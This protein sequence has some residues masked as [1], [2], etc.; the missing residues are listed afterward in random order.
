MFTVLHANHLEDLR[1]LSLELIH[2]QPLPPL[3]QETFLVQ[4]NG[5]AQWLRMA[6]AEKDGIA[7]S[8]D[9]PLPS[10]FVW[11]AYRAVLGNEI[12]KQSPFDKGPLTWRLMRLLPRLVGQPLFAPLHHY[13][14]DEIEAQTS[15]HKSDAQPCGDRK[16]FQLSAQLADLFD[17]YLVYRP[18]WIAAWERGE[19]APVDLADEDAWQPEL[20][21]I[22]LSDAPSYARHYHRAALHERFLRVARGLSERPAELPPRLF[23]FGISALPAQL[24]E[25]LHALSGVMDVVL[26]ISNPCRYYWGDVVTD[27]EAIRRAVRH[28]E[29]PTLAGLDPETL[30]LKANPLLAGWGTQGRDFIVALYDFEGANAFDLESDVFRERADS[31]DAPLLNQLQQDILD[32]VHPAERVKEEGA[33]RVIAVDDDSVSFTSAHSPLREVE[34]LHDQLLDAFERDATLKPRDVIVMVPDIDRY[35]PFIEAVFGQIPFDDPRYIPFTVADR[36]ATEA[37]PLLACVL[38]L[39]ELPERRLGVTEI[40]DWLDIPA[41]R[42]RCDI[43]ESDLER[44][45]QWLAGS[46]VRWGLDR[47]H[48]DDL[49]LPALHDNTW[50]FGLE[51]MLL[52]Y[53]TGVGGDFDG[54]V[55]YDEVGGL[56]AELAGKLAQLIRRLGQHRQRF[57]TSL[58]PQQ[59]AVQLSAMFETLFAL[60]EQDEFDTLDRVDRAIARWLDACTC[61]DFDSA[62]PLTVVRE[63][64]RQEL[65]Q[66]GLA[67]RFL[68]GKVNFATL[69]P[70]RAI[71]F[72]QTF[73]LGMNDGDY[74]RARLPQDFDLM[75]TRTRAGDRSRRDDDRYLFLE[76]LLSTRDRLTVS[77]IG[78]DQRDNIERAPSMLVGELLDTIALGWRPADEADDSEQA[79]RRRLI[80]QYPLQPFSMRY[81]DADSPFFTFD[82]SWEAAHAPGQRLNHMTLPPASPPVEALRLADLERLLRLPPGVCVS[83]RLGVRFHR[84]E[85]PVEDAEPFG[86]NG[87]ESYWLKRELLDE[88]RK[89]QSVVKVAEQ[90][91]RSGRL[92]ALG[93][94]DALL[95]GLIGPL[96]AQ[97]T[98]WQAV[99][100]T[101]EA[102]P[103]E[104]FATHWRDDDADIE[105][106]LDDVIDNLHRDT[107]GRMWWWTLEP[108][109]FGHLKTDRDGR[110]KSYGKPNRLFRP[111]LLQQAL[112]AMGK[113]VHIGLLF[114]DRELTVAPPAS[115]EASQC[116]QQLLKLWWQARQ[117]PLAT[118]PELAFIWLAAQ[119]D[120]QAPSGDD[121]EAAREAARNLYEEASFNGM[122]ALR[123]REP[124]L[125][126]LWGDFD[127]LLASGF[128]FASHAVY[129]EFWSM[130]RGL[131]NA[132]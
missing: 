22:L 59:W 83:E 26:M 47:Q 40:L 81:F 60:R 53:A 27:R 20:W 14:S 111:W 105:L 89:G 51:R 1:E 73:L 107:E 21:R 82:T 63:S 116:M 39:L 50:R 121:Q 93:F 118:A 3:T 8:L 91:R 122:A 28:A 35:A 16:C 106:T 131:A 49:G 86:L 113:A 123:E 48:R 94:G 65:D 12:P 127:A 55:A 100:E 46:G 19:T 38:Q 33:K 80:R 71:P 97:L 2:R 109:H 31:A 99:S 44:T 15:Q 130:V 110:L 112:A 92:P 13:L 66:G 45:R 84:P 10:S 103:A 114:E 67:Q 129:A 74:P 24:L 98:R 115:G 43:S 87:L 85:T 4:S 9:F 37:E 72:R 29:K 120:P 69:M 132:E 36:L 108:S 119:R 61:A 30:H 96:E 17:Q 41:F 11:R 32:L 126:E 70:M 104:R 25:A 57:A 75:A 64:I 6:L 79:L 76:A 5:M 117:T 90:L 124:M 95:N 7:A 52:G 42:R 78:R 58:T 56:D 68:A 23:V 77:W 102:L 101:L 62:V 18:D 125:G 128:E 34:I 54:I 88:A